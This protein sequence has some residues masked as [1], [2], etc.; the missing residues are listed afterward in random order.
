MRYIKQRCDRPRHAHWKRHLVLT[1]TRKKKTG[2]L[3]ILKEMQFY[4]GGKED[5]RLTLLYS[6]PARKYKGPS[7][8]STSTTFKFQN[9]HIPRP[10]APSCCFLADKETLET[11]LV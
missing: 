1:E 11:R 8:Q 4:E 9:S 10:L 3:S 5:R 6:F 2:R 7:D